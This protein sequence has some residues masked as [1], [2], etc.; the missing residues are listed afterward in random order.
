MYA[1]NTIPMDGH[2][3]TIAYRY[4]NVDYLERKTFIKSQSPGAKYIHDRHWT[5][6]DSAL[7]QA[8]WGFGSL[9][10]AGTADHST[11]QTST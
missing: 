9:E 4:R 11:H 8:K 3:L 6:A 2:G 7:L 5:V 1:P 10:I